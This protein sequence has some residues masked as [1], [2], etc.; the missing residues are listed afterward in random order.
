MK[1]S[2]K[3]I[4]FAEIENTI[5]KAMELSRIMKEVDKK[6]EEDICAAS[7]SSSSSIILECPVC[8]EKKRGK[9]VPACGHE[10]CLSCNVELI[11]RGNE[12]CVLCRELYKSIWN[13]K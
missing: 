11:K 7:S 1:A 5:K 3:Y 4:L 2:E 12:V 10:I 13:V 8:Y 9:V 6:E